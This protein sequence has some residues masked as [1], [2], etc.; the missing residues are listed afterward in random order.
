MPYIDRNIL[1]EIVPAEHKPT[2]FIHILRHVYCKSMTRQGFCDVNCPVTCGD[3]LK[4]I[5]QRLSDVGKREE[6]QSKAGL[7]SWLCVDAVADEME[8]NSN[9][10][11]VITPTDGFG[12]RLELNVFGRFLDETTTA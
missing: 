5:Y 7:F 9:N 10:R 6:I 4:R 11:T 12:Q 2:H 3:T 8:K 1:L